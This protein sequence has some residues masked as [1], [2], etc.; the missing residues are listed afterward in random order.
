V[1]TKA[2]LR[3]LLRGAP[4]AV[5]G[6]AREALLVALLAVTGMRLGEAVKLDHGDLDLARSRVRVRRLKGGREQW[7]PVPAKLRPLVGR[8]LDGPQTPGEPLFK[9]RGG[10]P[11]S[12]HNAQLWIRQWC[13]RAG[14]A[15]DGVVARDL[16]RSFAEHVYRDSGCDLVLTSQA[17]GHARVSTTAHYLGWLPPMTEGVIAELGE[18]LLEPGESGPAPA[19]LHPEGRHVGLPLRCGCR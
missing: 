6:E 8:V 15:G 17:L 5:E 7:L 13:D 3:R 19:A 4:H 18:S 2:E 11:V 16:R 12:Q 14:A 10:R 9:G 1:L